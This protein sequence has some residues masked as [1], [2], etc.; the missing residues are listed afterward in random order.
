MVNISKI[1]AEA[2]ENGVKIAKKVVPETVEAATDGA[3]KVT[4]DEIKT[5]SDAHSAL[6]KG[7]QKVRDNATK[8]ATCN[9]KTLQEVLDERGFKELVERTDNGTYN[10]VITKGGHSDTYCNGL[11]KQNA[12]ECYYK[13][14]IITEG[15]TRLAVNDVVDAINK[16]IFDC[17]SIKPTNF[18]TYLYRG[19][20]IDADD[21]TAAFLNGDNPAWTSYLKY[22][23]DAKIGDVITPDPIA[24]CAHWSPQ[25]AAN[26]GNTVFAIKM[27]K[28]SKYFTNDFEARI[29]P[30]A[31]F[32]VTDIVTYDK[33][34]K[35]M[36]LE[37]LPESL[38]QINVEDLLKFK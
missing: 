28:G 31:Q 3:R 33:N 7:G 12:R 11:I 8:L 15:K 23:Q 30:M 29:A 5:A 25:F 24:Q 19:V 13:G 18:D 26:N 27:P 20:N 21:V 9:T 4:G 38:K 37:Y 22:M 10:L 36:F 16:N 32:R 2:V 6:F 35:V 1:A 17:Q 34:K 14:Q